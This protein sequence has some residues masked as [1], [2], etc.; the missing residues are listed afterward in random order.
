MGMPGGTKGTEP[1]AMM[2]SRAVT[3]PPTSTRPGMQNLYD[4]QHSPK[5]T[6]HHQLHDDQQGIVL[7]QCT[8]STQRL[9]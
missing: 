3:V 6:A 5:C 2:M 9:G 4:S 8:T 1:V 7:C